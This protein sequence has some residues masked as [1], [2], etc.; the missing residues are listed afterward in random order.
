MITP[1]SD[2]E[3]K[4]VR[5]QVHETTQ[6]ML[7]WFETGHLPEHLTAVSAPFGD[8]AWT[9]AATF[10]TGGPE[11]TAALRKL[12]EAKDCAVRCALFYRLTG[13]Q[14]RETLSDG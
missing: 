14:P 10:P 13:R 8:L 9:L 4:Y 1:R 12:L 3:R 11:L 7:G 6:T 5:A 2:A